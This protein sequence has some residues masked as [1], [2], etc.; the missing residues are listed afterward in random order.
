ML[1]TDCE[2]MQPDCLSAI[3]NALEGGARLIQLREK[4]MSSHELRELAL[5]ASSLC[6]EYHGTLVINS[7]ENLAREAIAGV[8]WP[9]RR[10]DDVAE[11]SEAL[12]SGASVHSVEA[13]QRA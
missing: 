12:L 7:E 10:L 8:H 9:E 3:H 2:A 5:Q 6:R 11:Y 13:A 4:N 1:V